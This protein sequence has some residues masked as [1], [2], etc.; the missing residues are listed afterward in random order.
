MKPEKIREMSD[1]ELMNQDKDLS[2]QLFRLRF[3]LSMG[4]T[5]SLKKIRELR[6]DIARI[7]TVRRERQIQ[8]AREAK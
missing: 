2:D 1:E 4:Q 3:Q 5:E 7:K 8:L 6:K